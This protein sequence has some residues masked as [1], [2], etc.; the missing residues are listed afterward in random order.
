MLSNLDRCG[1]VD[2]KF[3]FCKQCIT[4]LRNGKCPKYGSINKLPR[5]TC[6]LYPPALDGL[7][8]VEEAAIARAHPVI[9]ILKLRPNRG[10]NPTAYH[11][12]KEYVVLLP[13]NPFLFYPCSH[14]RKSPYMI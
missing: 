1:I 2:K 3:R 14:L 10:F 5:A 11:A 13:Q 9:S 4:S 8:I 12:I 6:Q 7:S